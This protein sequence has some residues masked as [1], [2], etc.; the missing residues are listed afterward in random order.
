ML[1]RSRE[2]GN[3][4]RLAF[5]FVVVLLAASSA[6]AQVVTGLPQFGS[7]GGGSFDTIN[8]ANANVFFAIPVLNKPGQGMPFQYSIAY[9]SSVYTNQTSSGTVAWTPVSG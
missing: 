3:P 1:R 5:L 6:S 9:N 2:G 8:E 7:F 4:L